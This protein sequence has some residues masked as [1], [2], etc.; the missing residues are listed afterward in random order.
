MIIIHLFK[1]GLQIF[2]LDTLG[3]SF[4]FGAKVHSDLWSEKPRLLCHY[5]LIRKENLSSA[6]SSSSVVVF[7]L[8]DLARVQMEASK[9]CDLIS[10]SIHPLRRWCSAWSFYSTFSSLLSCDGEELRRARIKVAGHTLLALQSAWR[11]WGGALCDVW[12]QVSFTIGT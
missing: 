10:A 7:C 4:H 5:K 9:K 2:T 3:V 8:S 6:S 1:A 12:W 11:W